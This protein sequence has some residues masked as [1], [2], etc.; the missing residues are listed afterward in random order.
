MD[1]AECAIF[2]AKQE[3]SIEVLYANKKFYSML[4]YTPEEFK[5]KFN[6]YFIDVMLSEEKQR[7]KSL[8][9]RQ[10]AAGGFCTL[11]FVW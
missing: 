4:Q 3:P 6:N 10:S 11:N 7:V 9:A 5:E 8:I 1:L 2:T